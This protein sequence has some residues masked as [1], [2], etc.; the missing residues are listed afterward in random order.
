M[1]E[2][3]LGKGRFS[4]VNTLDYHR[5][6]STNWGLSSNGYVFG[7]YEG[8]VVYLH[9]LIAGTP[10]GLETDHINGIKT[11]NRRSNL[12]VVTHSQNNMNQ[13]KKKGLNPFKGITKDIRG[14]W[15]V[16]IV[17]NGDRHTLYGFKNPRHAALAYDLWARD[18]HG[19]FSNTNFP[20]AVGN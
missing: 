13:P 6:K 16:Q 12:R 1:K 10:K 11:D 7:R 9:R 20:L 4:K 14:N 8:K 19:E 15:S 2:I 5:Y 3:S 18:L 17:N